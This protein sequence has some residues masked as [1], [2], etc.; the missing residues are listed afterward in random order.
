MHLAVK[1]NLSKVKEAKPKRGLIEEARRSENIA[2]QKEPERRSHFYDST[3][4]TDREEVERVHNEEVKEIE[5]ITY[6]SESKV[7]KEDISPQTKPK[8]KADKKSVHKK[9][10]PCCSEEHEALDCPTFKALSKED[11]RKVAVTK[12][13]CFHCL[14]RRHKWCKEFKRCDSCGRGHNSALSCPPSRAEVSEEA[15][16]ESKDPNDERYLKRL[17]EIEKRM[18]EIPKRLQEGRKNL[19]KSTRMLLQICNMLGCDEEF[20]NDVSKWCSELTE[21]SELEK[22]NFEAGHHC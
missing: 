11:R 20:Q 10:C 9:G 19:Q 8:G 5:A 21:D 18:E 22:E 13:L 17:E 1:M 7:V 3:L 2:N 12:R 15:K 14:K 16:E 6:S 4:E